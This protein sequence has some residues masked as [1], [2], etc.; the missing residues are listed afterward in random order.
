M[1]VY[2]ESEA[3]RIINGESDKDRTDV[4]RRLRSIDSVDMHLLSC[5]S[6]IEAQAYH[7]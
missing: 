1:V 5:D 2:D 3:L 4:C 6:H 7:Q